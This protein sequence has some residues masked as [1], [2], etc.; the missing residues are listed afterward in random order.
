MAQVTLEL[1]HQ[2]HL[3]DKHGAFP[4]CARISGRENG[5][6]YVLADCFGLYLLSSSFAQARLFVPLHGVSGN[7]MFSSTNI[8]TGGCLS[9]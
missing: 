9:G 5:K 7:E 4:H 3:E 8:F 1:L 6:T 2:V